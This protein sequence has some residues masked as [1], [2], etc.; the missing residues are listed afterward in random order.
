MRNMHFDRASAVTAA[1][2]LVGVVAAC[3]GGEGTAPSQQRQVATA[4][5]VAQPVSAIP[6]SDVDTIEADVV[7]TVP[8][9]VTY[10]DAEAVYHTGRYADAT[11]MFGVYTASHPDN[12]WGHYMLGL[13]AWKAGDPER[14]IMALE[15]T[16]ELDSTN[17]KARTNLGRV[18]IEQGRA[19]DALAHLEVARTLDPQSA[20]VLRVLG[21]AMSEANRPEEA[22]VAYREAL[23]ID[24][25][26]AWTM[27]NYALQLIRL[28]RFEDALPPL[29]RAVELKPGSALFQNNLGVA[30]ERSG[31]PVSAAAA[32]EAALA[33]DE[34][35]E[36]AR[37]SLARVQ[38]HITGEETSLTDLGAL[39]IA[40]IGEVESWRMPAPEILGVR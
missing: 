34:S 13:S 6:V 2:A 28:S 10:S 3:D 40:F 39:A 22:L 18:L 17:V 33:A 8:E 21:N 27:N 15:R 36:R 26:D 19:D 16:V 1:I 5:P 38:Q 30:L 23:A 14:A 31:D 12:G 25:E 9:N 20:S 29:A 11:E 4:R 7:S 37:I 35:H 24:P 32:Y